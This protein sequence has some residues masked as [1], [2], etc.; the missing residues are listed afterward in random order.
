M[1]MLKLLPIILPT[2]VLSSFVTRKGSKL[3]YEG[4]IFTFSGVNIYWLGQDE[5]NPNVPGG[6]AS[7]Y[8]HPSMV[9]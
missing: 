1:M 3:F 5:N 7:V 2:V 8:Y 6:E 4:D 9:R